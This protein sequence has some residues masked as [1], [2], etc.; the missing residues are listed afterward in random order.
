MSRPTKS[1]AELE[2]AE[3]IAGG[4]NLAHKVAVARRGHVTAAGQREGVVAL[5]ATVLVLGLGTY[6]LAYQRPQAKTGLQPD[7]RIGG[8]LTWLAPNPSG[9]NAH[10]TVTSLA[11]IFQ[12]AWRD[13]QRELAERTDQ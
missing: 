6:R 7:H 11:D 13:H 3:Y 10:E 4:K 9:L 2:R 12:A 1:A 5:P 8:A